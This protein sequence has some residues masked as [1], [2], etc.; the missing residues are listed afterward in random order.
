ML[1]K[2]S[3]ALSHGGTRGASSELSASFGTLPAVIAVEP[4]AEFSP[5]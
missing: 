1:S 2:E 5:K 3:F 4:P